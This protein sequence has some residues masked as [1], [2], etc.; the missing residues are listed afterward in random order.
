M[1]RAAPCPNPPATASAICVAAVAHALVRV[2]PALLPALVLV[3]TR[4]CRVFPCSPAS[5][6]RLD[7]TNNGQ[8]PRVHMSVDAARTSAYAT[9][10]G[11]QGSPT[12]GQC[13]HQTPEP[14]SSLRGRP[15]SSAGR[16]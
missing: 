3:R 15:Q 6:P 10:Q 4:C 16:E 1:S 11:K 5:H 8:Q 2:E 14:R 13:Q 12:N 7:S 9:S